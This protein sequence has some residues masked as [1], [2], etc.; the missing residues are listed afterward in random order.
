MCN[1]T[2][3]PHQN[4]RRLS[5]NSRQPEIKVEV[6]SYDDIDPSLSS[7]PVDRRNSAGAF[8]GNHPNSMGGYIHSQQKHRQKRMMLVNPVIAAH[9]K[10]GG[11]V[12]VRSVDGVK[13]WKVYLPDSKPMQGGV[14]D[15][16]SVGLGIE[17]G[18]QG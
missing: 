14:Q 1:P 9:L 2:A 6:T 18:V 3:S 4:D 13:S 8:M 17:I 11:A 7:P 12:N 10:R 16:Q 15:S 5:E